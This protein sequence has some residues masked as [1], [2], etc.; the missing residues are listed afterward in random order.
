MLNPLESE[1]N[2]LLA[3]LL[4]RIRR[5]NSNRMPSHS[6]IRHMQSA[7]HDSKTARNAIYLA[8]LYSEKAKAMR[9]EPPVPY[10]RVKKIEIESLKNETRRLIT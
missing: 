3:K 7:Y 1:W 9:F 2:F 8:G 6:E 10:S 4:G 5:F